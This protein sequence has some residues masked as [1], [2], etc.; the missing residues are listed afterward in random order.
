MSEW[1]LPPDVQ[2]ANIER[3]GGGGFA[4]ES[5]VY[6]ATVK[7]VYLNQAESEAVSFNVILENST[8]KELRESYWIKSGK[9]KGHKTYYTKDGENFPL[10]GYSV[11]Q[12]LCV[13]ATGKSLSDVMKSAEKKMV[14]LY[15]AEAKKE[16]PTER[17]VLSDLTGKPVK[18]AIHQI[19]ENKRKKND[20]T[21][22][23]ET[24]A[25][26]RTINECK[27]FGNMEG[28]TADEISKNQ[29]AEFFDKWAEK[30]TG[31]VIDKTNKNAGAT[32]AADLM[33]TPPAESQPSLFG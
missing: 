19:T 24:T 12:S 20:T 1:D 2:E 23:Y 18:A 9:A 32:S 6:D 33:N 15:N 4:W 28:K 11:A 7:M 26:T 17:P 27:F 30:N 21:G 13:A 16:V 8:G 29:P 3:L 14:N 10:P 5:G 22:K 31:I 25:E